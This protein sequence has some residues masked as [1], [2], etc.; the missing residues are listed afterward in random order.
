MAGQPPPRL[1]RE[2]R[3]LAKK[4]KEERTGARRRRKTGAAVKRERK[5]LERLA[6][7]QAAG[8]PPQALTPTLNPHVVAFVPD[9]SLDD[10]PRDVPGAPPPPPPFDGF[11]PFDGGAYPGGFAGYLGEPL[12]LIH[13]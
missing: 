11:Q 3:G 1:S 10:A 9:F 12:S 6:L 13:I 8:S 4:T 7:A 5:A 2:A